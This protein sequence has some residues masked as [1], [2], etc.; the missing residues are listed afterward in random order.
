MIT[1]VSQD[2]KY[3]AH[4]A[5]DNLQH[6]KDIPAQT[7]YCILI[8]PEGDFSHPEIELAIQNNFLPITLGKKRLRTETAALTAC[9]FLNF[10]N[11]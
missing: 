11:A 6:F 2:Q 4:L 7:S 3:I 1:S 8:G 9:Q 10:L 5:D